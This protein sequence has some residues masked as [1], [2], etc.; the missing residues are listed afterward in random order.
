MKRQDE[1]VR[2]GTDVFGFPAMTDKRERAL[3]FLEEALELVQACGL[4]ESDVQRMSYHVFSRDAGDTDQE[5][6]GAGVT[7]YAL[8]HA[9]GFNLETLVDHEIARVAR[10]K[11]K[12]RKK[13]ALKPDNIFSTRCAS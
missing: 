12:I 2:I 4:K 8:A 7:L 11:D 1:I 9:R 6:G 3:R 5:L 10:N 13:S